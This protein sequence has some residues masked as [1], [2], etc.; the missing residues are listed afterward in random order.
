MIQPEGFGD[1]AK[2][3]YFKDVPR[4]QTVGKRMVLSTLKFAVIHW[5]RKIP[6][7]PCLVVKNEVLLFIYVDEILVL[8]TTKQA[9]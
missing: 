5:I 1:G 7:E 2:C 9:Y 8:S 3:L 4:A 6:K